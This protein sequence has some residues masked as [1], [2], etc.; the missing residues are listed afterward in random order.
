MDMYIQYYVKWKGWDIE[1]STW[2]GVEDVAGAPEAVKE[3]HKLYPHKPS[4][5]SQELAS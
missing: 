5:S 1:D 2:Q 4:P 3:F